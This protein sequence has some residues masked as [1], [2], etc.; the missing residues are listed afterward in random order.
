MEIMFCQHSL[1]LLVPGYNIDRYTV[2]LFID[3][4]KTALTNAINDIISNIG[5]LDD[6]TTTDKSSIVNAVNELVS[7][8]SG[9]DFVCNYIN[10]SSMISDTAL[11]DGDIVSTTGYY[12]A[13]DGGAGMYYITASPS[14]LHYETLSNGLYANLINDNGVINV[15]QWGAYGDNIHDDTAIVQAIFDATV[16]NNTI[17]PSATNGEIGYKIYFPRGTYYLTS[18]NIHYSMGLHIIGDGIDTTVFSCHATNGTA[19]D[20]NHMFKF[21]DVVQQFT[22]SDCSFSNY[23]EGY[24]TAIGSVAGTGMAASDGLWFGRFENLKFE[25]F[26]IS[27]YF[28]A[29]DS[30]S[31]YDAANQYFTFENC[32]FWRSFGIDVA[33]IGQVG[34]NSFNNCYFEKPLAGKI[35]SI[36]LDWASSASA[37]DRPN[38]WFNNCSWVNFAIG[39]TSIINVNSSGGD[40]HFNGCWFESNNIPFIRV[41][42][43][44]NFVDIEQCQFRDNVATNF[45]IGTGNNQKLNLFDNSNFGSTYTN[46]I[47]STLETTGFIMDKGVMGAPMFTNYRM[48]S[49]NFPRGI[50]K[51]SFLANSVLYDLTS[52]IA[53]F[54]YLPGVEIVNTLRHASLSADVSFIM[55]YD[56]VNY[57]AIPLNKQVEIKINNDGT[58]SVDFEG[59]ITSTTT[60]RT[61][62]I[63]NTSMIKAGFT[64]YDTTLNALVVWNG[65]AWYKMTAT[66]I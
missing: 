28:R 42:G 38:A 7:A 66:A 21:Y 41:G 51:C 6:L 19:N 61:T 31:G 63:T 52:D 4:L 44:A 5:D 50:E 26:Y 34:Q 12:S 30:E 60:G 40:Y 57:H 1:Q 27:V 54:K 39:Q 10:V 64:Y 65:S 3:D 47:V 29:V 43:A 37:S 56:G 17:T 22:F 33:M 15:K 2:E 18:V 8:I 53:G 11:A 45:M 46:A 23:T 24:N 9:V 48:N 36:T 25:Y 35:Y 59:F 20:L 62:V 58:L 49:T 13:N 55:V 16:N 32:Y 14:A